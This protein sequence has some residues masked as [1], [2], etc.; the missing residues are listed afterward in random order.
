VCGLADQSVP[1]FPKTT[2]REIKALSDRD[3]RCPNVIALREIV[4]L[5]PSAAHCHALARAD[6]AVLAAAHATA[7]SSGGLD[8]RFA[9]LDEARAS[10]WRDASTPDQGCPNPDQGES[11]DAPGTIYMVFDWAPYD[12]AGLLDSKIPRT[13][14]LVKSYTFQLLRALDVLHRR[15][16]VHR[17]IKSSN[18]LVDDGNTLK[19]ADFGLTRTVEPIDSISRG[20][21]TNEVITLWYRPPELLLGASSYGTEVDIWSVGCILLELALGRPVFATRSNSTKETLGRIFS[22][23]GTPPAG[24]ALRRLPGWDESFFPPS[25]SRLQATLDDKHVAHVL[26][27][28]EGHAA[29]L[30]TGMLALD[31]ADRVAAHQALESQWFLRLPALNRDNPCEGLASVSS[32]IDVSVDHHEFSTKQRMKAARSQQQEPASSSTAA[33]DVP[34]P[35]I[36]RSASIDRAEASIGRP[37]V[38]YPSREKSSSPP[39]RPQWR[40]GDGMGDRWERNDRRDHGPR[41]RED[42]RREGDRGRDGDWHRESD[43]RRHDRWER[44]DRRERG[45]RDRQEWRREDGRGHDDEGYWKRESDRRRHDRRDDDRWGRDDRPHDR[46][47]HDDRPHDRHPHDDRPHDR[48]PH[49]DGR[50]HRHYR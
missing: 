50:R 31:P 19:L 48:H 29:R 35:S 3:L 27:D 6:E 39:P 9:A 21:M 45:P 20:R 34:P 2:V 43:R 5:L 1:Q 25:S 15:S 33:S 46:H 40:R 11:P 22:L 4:T 42:W 18:L 38:R 10:V 16:Y 30:I 13:T 23:L 12:L 47:P 26:Q 17:D 14:L 28:T 44:D 37:D 41:D 49:S 36:E 32:L 7:A 8:P 24:S